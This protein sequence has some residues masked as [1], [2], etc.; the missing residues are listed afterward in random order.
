MDRRLIIGLVVVVLVVAWFA[1][2]K[3]K[4]SDP[5]TAVRDAIAQMQASAEKKNVK[6][7][8][9]HISKRFKGDDITR[10]QIKAA[11]F[12]H[13]QRGSWNR[14][15]IMKI[16]VAIHGPQSA[17]TYVDCVLARGAATGDIADVAPNNAAAF[18]FTLGWVLEDDEWKI[19]SG[20]YRKMSVYD[21]L[22]K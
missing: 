15:F 5:E 3:K 2:R 22:G 21:A 13:L 16:D 10:D 14:V 12:V 18:R 6:E 9:S 4:P 19:V 11:L 17:D 20:A 7:V 1:L 8:M